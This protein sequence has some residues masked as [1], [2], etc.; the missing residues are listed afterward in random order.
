MAR[1]LR[2]MYFV[3]GKGDKV[4]DFRKSV[5]LSVLCFSPLT[6]SITQT[7]GSRKCL[8]YI[9]CPFFFHTREAP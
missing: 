8:L 9:S 3:T 7:E 6:F 4:G 2:G 5:F 1:E